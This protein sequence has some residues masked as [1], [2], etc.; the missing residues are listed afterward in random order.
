M[1]CVP[2]Q[3]ESFTWNGEELTLREASGAAHAAYLDVIYG[4]H[5]DG[6]PGPGSA[7]AES[8][9]IGNCLFRGK[10]PV[11][12]EFA[13]ALPE[14]VLTQ[15]RKKLK[16]WEDADDPKDEPKSSQDGSS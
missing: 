2:E 13:K 8:A 12:L 5:V 11:G 3:T 7:L 4:S 9:L 16:G 6:R 14:R 1:N 15:L 10:E